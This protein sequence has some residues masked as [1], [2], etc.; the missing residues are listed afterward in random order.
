MFEFACTTSPL[1]E[2]PE[3]SNTSSIATTNANINNYEGVPETT[4]QADAA[5]LTSVKNTNTQPANQITD[6]SSERVENGNEFL[7]QD[8]L[9]PKPVISN[10]HSVSFNQSNQV[11][12]PSN[13]LAANGNSSYL[14]TYSREDKPLLHDNNSRYTVV[15]FIYIFRVNMSILGVN[16]GNVGLSSSFP[17]SW[18]STV[19]GQFQSILA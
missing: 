7:K 3:D 11:H 12:L 13:A 8:P 15:F 10:N 5:E 18:A 2:N 6:R 4:L 16:K 17:I 19:W 9:E 1:P 14:G